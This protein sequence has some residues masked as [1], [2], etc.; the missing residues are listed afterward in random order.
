MVDEHS[1]WRRVC[2]VTQQWDR[3]QR[4]VGE[5][6]E[7]RDDEAGGKGGQGAEQIERIDRVI[8]LAAELAD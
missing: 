5:R 1:K 6:D 8:G 3:E 2:T 7:G 4:D